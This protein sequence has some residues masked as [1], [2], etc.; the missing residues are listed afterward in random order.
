MS[1]WEGTLSGLRQQTITVLSARAGLAG[2]VDQ[3]PPDTMG[4]SPDPQLAGRVFVGVSALQARQSGRADTPAEMV[5]S[6][7][8]LTVR[9]TST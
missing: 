5:L 1:R 6:T 2:V 8:T 4:L 7:I 9:A 3:E